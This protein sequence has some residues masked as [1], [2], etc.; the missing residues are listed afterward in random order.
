M[1]KLSRYL[2][3][4]KAKLESKGVASVRSR[5]I[6]LK[7]L[8]PTLTIDKM[9]EFM[10]QAFQEVYGGQAQP[11]TLTAADLRAIGETA[12]EYGSW[13]YLYGTSLP[14]SFTCQ[15]RYPWGGIEISLDAKK[16]NIQAAKVY[17]DS[18]DWAL[19]GQLE[20]ALVGCRFALSPMQEAIVAAL[21][22]E[23][24]A[25]DLCQLLSKQQI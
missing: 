7:E 20:A 5:V 23:T 25:A 21:D 9:A 8:A 19:P 13:D 4:S 12:Q 3:P 24:V 15:G 11:V 1:D 22:N 17:S 18:M 14:F 10:L 6:N 2:S 16:G